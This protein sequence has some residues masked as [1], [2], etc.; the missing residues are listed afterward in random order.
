LD[1]VPK[2]IEKPFWFVY[3]PCQVLQGLLL[4]P[5]AKQFILEE[6]N[7]FIVLSCKNFNFKTVGD[8]LI[9]TCYYLK[10]LGVSK[11][12]LRAFCREFEK[13]TDEYARS[14]SPAVHNAVIHP[15][16]PARIKILKNF[17]G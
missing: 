12:E 7:C 2:S 1:I 6:A 9:L 3:N 15:D 11:T 10:N 14:V 16:L 17:I 8:Y 13:I 5:R 4:C